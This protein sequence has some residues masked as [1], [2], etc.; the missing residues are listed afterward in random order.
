MEKPFQG[1][2]T[3]LKA[4]I[5]D[6]SR[7]IGVVGIPYDGSTSYRPGARFG[8]NA[9]RQ[10]SA[11]LTDGLHP[12]FE[13]DPRYLM[14]DWGDIITSNTDVSK[15][16]DQITDAITTDPYLADA[17]KKLLFIGGDHTI[18]LGI[19]R[20]IS[21]R[22]ED[23]RLIVFDAHCDTWADH[24]GD[25]LG[26]GTWV[27]NAVEE[28]LIPASSIMQIGLRSPVD[29]ATKKW[30]PE[31]GGITFSSRETMRDPGWVENQI[32]TFCGDHPV[33]VS[34]DI[35]VLDPAYAP[36]TGT[37]EIGGLSTMVVLDLIQ[38]LAGSD[39]IGMDLVEVNPSYDHAGITSL[40]AATILWTVA[41]MIGKQHEQRTQSP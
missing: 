21:T 33:Y 7:P 18:S 34:F 17:T 16:L 23:L 3:F 27:R 11:M 36:G 15:S 6:L 39:I 41:S 14:T 37:P 1:F 31:R 5:R 28:N 20:A 10:A 2:N 9:V 35:D 40:A 4:P 29:V 30:L 38:S 25:P 8:P 12:D 32:R 22:P 19:L 13:I 24:F 26:H